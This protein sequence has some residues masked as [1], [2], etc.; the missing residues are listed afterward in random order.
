[1]KRSF[2]HLCSPSTLGKVTLR[3]RIFAAPMGSTDITADCGVGPR[4]PGFYELRAKGGAAAVTATSKTAVTATTAT[5]RE[6][7][8]MARSP[9]R[10]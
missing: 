3:N 6:V 9:F 1:M 8:P 10:R 5:L 4:T 7:E 2:P